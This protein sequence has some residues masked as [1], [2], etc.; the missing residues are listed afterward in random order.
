MYH[1][2]EKQYGWLT[3]LW[4]TDNTH[5]NERANIEFNMI[6]KYVNY[7]TE[8]GSWYWCKL[9]GSYKSLFTAFVGGMRGSENFY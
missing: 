6:N 1:D 2:K 8:M 7:I 9:T 4:W 5:S 3:N